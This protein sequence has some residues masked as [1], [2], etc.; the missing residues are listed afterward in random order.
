MSEHRVKIDSIAKATPEKVLSNADLEKIVDT[1][2]EWIRTRTGMVERR[3]SNENTAASDLVY[4]AAEKALKKSSIKARDIDLIVIATVTG[5]HPFP[6]TACIVQSKLGIHGCPAFDISA[7]CSGF[8]YAITIAKQFLQNGFVHNVLVAGVEILTKITNWKDRGTCVLFGD[9]AGAA[10]LTE[11]HKGEI[12]E[13]I[14]TFIS[15]DGKYG[16][17]LIQEAG[18]SRMPAS[19]ETVEKNLHTVYMEGNKIFKIA[20]KS[21][22]DAADI[23]LT[24][25]GFTGEDLDWLVPHQANLRI[26]DATAKRLR[27]LPQQVI[28]NI[29]KY[30]NTSSASIPLAFAEAVEDGRIRRG[31]LIVLDAFGAGLT[32]GSVL[33]RY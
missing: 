31:D 33:L 16:N 11:A 14:D 4:E 9:G 25:N 26:I 17:L 10:I 22:G 7:G 28:I 5:D 15:A 13:I 20:V 19:K 29:E 23:I 3:I 27:L 8:I 21:M 30:G 6:S 2:D 24:R 18:G 12:S 1:S 32:W